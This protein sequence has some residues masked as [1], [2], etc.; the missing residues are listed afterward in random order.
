MEIS[1]ENDR[2]NHSVIKHYIGMSMNQMRHLEVDRIIEER[3]ITSFID[4]G[5]SEGL[6]LQKLSRSDAIQLAIGVDKDETALSSAVLVI[7]KLCRTLSLKIS[8][9]LSS[10]GE[11]TTSI[12]SYT[13]VTPPRNTRK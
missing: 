3:H 6:L 12:Y 2:E 1:L 8:S 7:A 9:S 4:F 5:C 13:A 10:L 11:S